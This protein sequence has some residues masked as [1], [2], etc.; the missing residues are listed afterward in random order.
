MTIGRRRADAIVA[1]RGQSEYIILAVNNPVMDKS[2]QI[3]FD[4]CD[5]AACDG[6]AGHCHAVPAC[7]RK[8]LEQEEPFAPPLLLSARLCS[9]CGACVRACP[10]GAIRL[11]PY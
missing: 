11:F 2:T 6:G 10:L 5:A 4:R 3:D 8:L 9:G 7:S 1:R